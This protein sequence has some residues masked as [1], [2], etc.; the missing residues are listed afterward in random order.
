[1][2][3]TV[4]TTTVTAVTSAAGALGAIAVL[5]LIGFLVTKELAGADQ[6]PW[7]RTLARGLNAAI[8]PL[9]M[10][11]ASILVARVAQAL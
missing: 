4:T 11:F 9:V 8:V 3:S 10:V 6:R 1:M 5:V 2:I 7:L